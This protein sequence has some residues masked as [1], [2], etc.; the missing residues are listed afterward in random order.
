M[1]LETLRTR[2]P[3]EKIIERMYGYI[4]SLIFQAAINETITEDIYVDLYKEFHK[5]TNT[6]P[7]FCV[8]NEFEELSSQVESVIKSLQWAVSLHQMRLEK[9][10]SKLE[11]RIKPT[12]ADKCNAFTDTVM[13]CNHTASP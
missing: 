1:D 5:Q 8:P 7:E 4:S 11:K 6:R 3:V 13:V 12:K 10:R 9:I 2:V